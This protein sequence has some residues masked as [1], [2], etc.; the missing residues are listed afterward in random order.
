MTLLRVKQTESLQ[1]DAGSRVV[2][3]N[4]CSVPLLGRGFFYCPHALSDIQEIMII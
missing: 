3:R 4:L 2:P 1:K